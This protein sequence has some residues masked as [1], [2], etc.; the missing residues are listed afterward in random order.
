MNT[1]CSFDILL[2]NKQKEH[3]N[4]YFHS[5]FKRATKKDFAIL[6]QET[7]I[8]WNY[9]RKPNLNKRQEK[10]RENAVCL[11]DWLNLEGD[12]KSTCFRSPLCLPLGTDL[13]V[14]SPRASPQLLLPPSWSLA[15]SYFWQFSPYDLNLHSAI[16]LREHL[17]THRWY[18]LIRVTCIS[19]S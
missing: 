7:D 12:T 6:P 15:Q 1:K 18:T 13:S 5:S 3:L 10:R 19:N 9:P 8:L 16:P 2:W 11:T 17:P 14:L 4:D